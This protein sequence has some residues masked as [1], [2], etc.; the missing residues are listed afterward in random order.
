MNFPFDENKAIAIMLFVTRKL[1]AEKIKA[2]LHKVFKIIY[3]ADQK[4]LV[5]YGRPVLTGD[6]YIAMNHGPVPSRVYDIIK[7]I[8][9]E[10][11]NCSCRDYSS[12]LKV[13]GH[14]LVP[15]AEPDLDE[16]SESDVACLDESL[17]EN[18][19]LS[20]IELRDKSH[21]GAYNKAGKDD[22]IS[23]K[24]IAKVAGADHTMLKYLSAKLEAEAAFS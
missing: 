1:Y 6:D 21:D 23:L 24:E 11:L 2:D 3:F 17:R 19:S 20:F 8:R 4:H 18:K 16:L 14:F 10:S 7:T 12:F 22:K 15:V 9:G 13:N 5:R